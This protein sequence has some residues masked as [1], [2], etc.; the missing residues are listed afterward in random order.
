MFQVVAVILALRY[1]V[2]NDRAGKLQPRL[3]I[4]PLGQQAFKIHRGKGNGG[5]AGFLRRLRVLF[6]PVR[7]CRGDIFRKTGIGIGAFL[8]LADLPRQHEAAAYRH[9]NADQE[10][11]GCRFA[12]PG[13]S[14]LS[15]FLVSAQEK[16]NAA[17][18]YRR[19]QHADPDIQVIIIAC[20][21]DRLRRIGRRCRVIRG[22]WRI[23][24]FFLRLF[25]EEAHLGSFIGLNLHCGAIRDD[26]VLAGLIFHLGHSVFAHTQPFN[27]DDTVLRACESLAVGAILTFHFKGKTV[28]AAIAGI[29]RDFQVAAVSLIHK[30]AAGFTIFHNDNLPVR[31][32]LKIVGVGVQFVSL[33]GSFLFDKIALRQEAAHFM[34]PFIGFRQLP[35]Q[36]V[37][38]IK[39]LIAVG[40]LIKL[41][42][43][44][45][46]PVEERVVCGILAGIVSSVFFRFAS[47]TFGSVFPFLLDRL[48]FVHS[49]G[50]DDLHRTMDQGV[51]N[52]DFNG[53]PIGADIDMVLFR[54]DGVQG[55]RAGNLLDDPMAERH[56]LKGEGSVFP[57]SR[58]QQGIFLGKFFRA[59]SKQ[60]DQ[61]ALQGK[62]LTAFGVL[63]VF[64]AVNAPADHLVGNGLAVIDRNRH[65]SGFLPGIRKNYRV[66]LAGK[67]ERLIG[68]TL[69][70]IE[71]A[72]RQIGGK[73]SRILAGR[74]LYRCNRHDFQKP[75]CGNHAAIQ[76]SQIL[77]C[78]QTKGNI[79]V[80]LA[81]TN[82][83]GFV[84]FQRFQKVDLHLL[85]FI[86]KPDGRL[87]DLYLLTGIGKLGINWRGVQHHA[88][89]RL[90][91]LQ[92]VAAQVLRFADR[93]SVLPSG[94][95]SDYRIFCHPQRA[96]AGINIFIGNQVIHSSRLSNYLINRLIEAIV[97]LHAGKSLAGFA[98]GKLGFLR[99]VVLHDGNDRLG[100]IHCERH[101]L[102]RKDIPF[103][104]CY[105]VKFK[106]VGGQRLRQHQP[107]V[108]RSVKYVNRFRVGIVDF[109]ADKFAGGKVLNTEA[110]TGHRNDLPG[111]RIPFFHTHP[112][113]DGVIVQDIGVGLSVLTDKYR[114]IRYKGFIVLARGLVDGIAAI[115]HILGGGK[116]VRIRRQDVPLAFFGIFIAARAC[117]IDLKN[118]AFLRLFHHT[119]IS[120]IAVF[121]VRYIRVWVIGM[122][123]KLDIAADHRLR[124]RIFR[125]I[126]LDFIKGRRSAHLMHRFIQQVAGA[127]GN[128]LQGPVIPARIVAGDKAAVRPG[129]EGIY[130]LPAFIQAIDSPRQGSVTLGFAGFCV[131]LMAFHTEFLQDIGKLDAGS[132]AALDGDILRSRRYIAVNGLLCHKISA[133]QKIQG[134]HAV[135]AGNNRFL[136]AVAADG[137]GNPLNN[138]VLAGLYDLC[139]AIGFRLDLHIEGNGVFGARHHGLPALA[140][141]DQHGLADRHIFAELERHRGFQHFL[142]GKGVAVTAAGHGDPAGSKGLQVDI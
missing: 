101:R 3:D 125:G 50:L 28:L 90:A 131:H 48:Q 44:A 21:R 46:Q 80:F 117:Q 84:C 49:L 113:S 45:R 85:A 79:L 102:V 58:H 31:S 142:A 94:K 115:G 124:Q 136:H 105:F 41:K 1:R 89:R 59:G 33:R 114:E 141:P 35:D 121:L 25:I 135:R 22:I 72:K 70:D 63:A 56:V 87:G 4:R 16:G 40:V 10:R 12:A 133:R 97:F 91:F 111:F 69:L 26:I 75:A 34:E 7:F 47:L 73:G 29:L 43:G 39:C 99:L 13:T 20:L 6:F 60:A 108:I 5:S 100:T 78:V 52:L 8:V 127:W 57:G 2:L 119:G 106:F 126:Q 81:K 132:L 66:L 24:R 55:R 139:L 138:T 71:A 134:H 77:R 82:A 123:H 17:A 74:V 53:L 76:G 18:D 14:F 65:Q 36:G 11:A 96:V 83:K 19:A 120:V 51:V 103:R 86:I 54:A 64:H 122:L 118:S 104:G 38:F 116:A 23:R 27:Q 137:K 107:A 140:P 67:Y 95:G 9:G 112:C 88:L 61:R 130:K 92:T 30:A 62:V 15:L 42:D 68:G 110:R 32:D 37:A 129:G 98:D 128:L 109:L 93:R